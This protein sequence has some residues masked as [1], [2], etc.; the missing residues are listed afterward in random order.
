MDLK[1]KPQVRR[2]GVCCL[3]KL[4]SHLSVQSRKELK[5]NDLTIIATVIAQ[6]NGTVYRFG[7]LSVATAN[8]EAST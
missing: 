3:V 8:I 1:Y 5:G 6:V 7:C 2:C 4:T